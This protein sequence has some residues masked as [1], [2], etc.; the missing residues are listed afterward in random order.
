MFLLRSCFDQSEKEDIMDASS[1][2]SLI[3]MLSDI[4]AEYPEVKDYPIRV[5]EDRISDQYLT[6]SDE[7]DTHKVR[8]V[9]IHDLKDNRLIC[10]PDSYSEFIREEPID[11]NPF[12]FLKTSTSPLSSI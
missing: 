1:V 10:L 7:D 5:I 12:S 11:I 9:E 4:V 3:K 2:G 6:F 8:F